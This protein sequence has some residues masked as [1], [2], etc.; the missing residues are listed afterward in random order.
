M[1]NELIF[2]QGSVV[3]SSSIKPVTVNKIADGKTDD[4]EL[5]PLCCN[6]DEMKSGFQ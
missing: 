4:K 2:I 1:S 3:C 6:V 5:S